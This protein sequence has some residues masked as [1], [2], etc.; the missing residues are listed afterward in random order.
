MTYESKPDVTV[1]GTDLVSTSFEKITREVK[2][3]YPGLDA[4]VSRRTRRQHLTSLRN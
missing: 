4:T 2:G 1:L 3:D